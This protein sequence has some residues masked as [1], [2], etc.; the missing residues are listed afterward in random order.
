M[1]RRL[2]DRIVQLAASPNAIWWLSA[3]AF[4][5]ASVFPIPPDILLIP[6]CLAAP[7]KSWRLALVA[8]LSSVLGGWLGYMIGWLFYD[9][10][11]RAIIDAY[12]LT[13]TFDHYREVFA[14]YGAWII[15]AK[16]WTPI[17]FKL[18]TIASGV[19]GLD[20]VTF[21]LAALGS[22]ALRFFL[23]AGL[24]WQFGEPIRDFIEKRLMLV[25]T[26]FVVLLVGGFALLKFI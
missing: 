2:Y 1:L 23:V 17:P 14:K 21:T 13:A 6:M 24:L 7:S 20:P 15:L 25:T 16:G 8:T 4:V 22:R 5:E 3:V 10:V 26:A 18:L 19:A 12:H 11:G 9:Q